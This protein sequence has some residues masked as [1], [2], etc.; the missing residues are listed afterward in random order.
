M[1]V[2]GSHHRSNCWTFDSGKA[3]KMNI[4]DSGL[5]EISIIRFDAHD[6]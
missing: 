2:I 6:G 5:L 4:N 1:E 3:F